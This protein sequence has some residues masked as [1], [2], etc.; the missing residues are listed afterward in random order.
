MYAENLSIYVLKFL[1]ALKRHTLIQHFSLTNLCKISFVLICLS[2]LKAVLKCP[3]T[4]VKLS[5]AL[6]KLIL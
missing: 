6:L 2:A 5:N 4:E 1:V 3:L